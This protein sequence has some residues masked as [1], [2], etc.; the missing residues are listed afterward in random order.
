MEDDYLKF[1]EIKKQIE[2]LNKRKAELEI[3][4]WEMNQAEYESKKTG[5]IEIRRGNYLVRF[6]KKETVKI[7]DTEKLRRNFPFLCNVKEAIT[8]KK[9]EY[10]TLP[11]DQKTIVDS[12]LETK[13]SKPAIT[14]SLSEGE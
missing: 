2:E 7:I 9:K 4:I 14:I 6:V 10:S 3:K 11:E 12:Y 5:T 8:L 1:I 13:E